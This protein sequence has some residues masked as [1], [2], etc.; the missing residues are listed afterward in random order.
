MKVGLVQGTAEPYAVAR[1]LAQYDRHLAQ[2][3]EK[4]AQLVLL[5]EFFP[6]GDT[7]EPEILR[8]A[9]QSSD[10]VSSWLGEAAG[11]HQMIV[12]GGYLSVEG[13]HVYNKLVIQ[14][15]DGNGC[16]HHGK[17]YSPVME[18]VAYRDSDQRE[19]KVDTSIGKIGVIVC[20][21]M[22]YAEVTSVDYSD[23]SMILIV[24]AMPNVIRKLVTRLTSIPGAL[25]R[26]NGV[27][28]MLC[29]MAGAFRS[30]G[31]PVWPVKMSGQ[32]A[33]LSGIY[34]PSGAVAGP[35]P[36]HETGTLFADIPLGPNVEAP[37]DSVPLESGLPWYF[38]WYDKLMRKKAQGIYQ[39]NVAR[40][41]REHR[42]S[43]SMETLP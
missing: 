1:N 30:K 17:T 20:I 42:R 37:D 29:S 24:F 43:G 35:M 9:I 6:T 38:Q 10:M 33:G 26:R 41:I 7:M 11:K 34:L 16:H 15:P 14:E 18:A 28:V 39:S 2:L 4:G 31:S 8:T 12:A 3:C 32:Y 23:C 21:E 27:P 36:G 5:P 13:E 22:N 40:W 25:A 19:Y